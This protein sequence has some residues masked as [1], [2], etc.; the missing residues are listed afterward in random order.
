MSRLIGWRD[1]PAKRSNEL[2][3]E[4]SQSSSKR[5]YVLGFHHC[6]VGD[7]L[8]PRKDTVRHGLSVEGWFAA[9]GQ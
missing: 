2:A 4:A 8:V 5:M 9:E 6:L 1:L 7:E 3:P